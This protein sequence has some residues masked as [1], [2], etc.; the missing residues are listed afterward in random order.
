MN[1]ISL[2]NDQWATVAAR[3]KG[4]D[5][6][7]P[8]WAYLAQYPALELGSLCALS[9]GLHPAFASPGWVLQAALPHFNGTDSD[10]LYPL[11]D[12]AE[13][14][15]RAALLHDFLQ[16]VG[17][18]AGNLSP[19][20]VLPIADGAADGER[21]VVKVADFAAWAD[22]MGW[23]L[24]P[25]FPRTQAGAVAYPVAPGGLQTGGAGWPWGNHETELLRK[26]AAAASQFWSLY[27]PADKTTAPTNQQVSEWLQKQGVSKPTA[28]VMA[29]ILRADGLPTGR[30]KS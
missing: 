27:D 16:R 17:I 24:P 10:E 4:W 25:E 20:G 8:D 13:G 14:T 12:A 30:R 19:R 18:A 11:E 21:T 7:A 28:D 6:F 23:N 1:T 3:V 26:M 2:T 15:K 9:V 22:G 29:T 5:I